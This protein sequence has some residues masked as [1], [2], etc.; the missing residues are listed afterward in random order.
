MATIHPGGTSP[1]LVESHPSDISPAECPFCFTQ[2]A[3]EFDHCVSWM[4][5]PCVGCGNTLI[6]MPIGMRPVTGHHRPTHEVAHR[7]A[8][9]PSHERRIGLFVASLAGL[10]NYVLLSAL[11]AGFVAE[12]KQAHDPYDIDDSLVSPF[13][14]RANG[15]TPLH[16][17][18]AR[19]ELEQMKALLAEGPPIEAINGKDRT[20]LYEASKRGRTAVV[21]LLLE[22]GANPNRKAA[23][24]Y[25]PM[26]A[27]AE[28]GHADTLAVLLS[29]GADLTARC[30]SG[31]T[32]LHRAALFGHTS[33]VRVLLDRGIN[34]NA[35]SHGQTAL[36]L[37]EANE[38][39][40]LIRL[41]RAHGGKEF[42]QAKAHL[43]K[44][45]AFQRNG[46]YNQALFAYADA[47][48]VD[49]ENPGAYLNRGITLIR[50]GS[51]DEALIALEE[52]IRLDPTLLEAYTH[53]ALIYSQR[54]QWAEAV[55]LWDGF[56]ARQPSNGR[57]YYERSSFRRAGGDVKG[58]MDDL[59]KACMFGY[60]KAC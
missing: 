20:A 16:L 48:A 2:N 8:S 9:V 32:A 25:T 59:Q 50:K 23:Q 43:E 31:E 44:G 51:Y 36:E 54:K 27:A 35:R 60:R 42:K 11:I 26:L 41:L 19:G 37:A 24:G 1:A 45:I 53:L 38:N 22:H 56:L 10:L 55:A 4:Q 6:L 29:H 49:P 33:V 13:V 12:L 15:W 34:V 18:A 30:E 3:Y 46:Q 14:L 5:F 7:D 58:F 40:E 39:E 17:A 47:L 57:A 28:R 52:A 21:S